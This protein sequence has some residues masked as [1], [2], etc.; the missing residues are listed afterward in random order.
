MGRRIAVTGA[1]GFIGG[2]LVRWLSR[3]GWWIRILTRHPSASAAAVDEGGRVEAVVGSLDDRDSLRR[4]VGGV[5][6]V[7]HAAGLVK[8]RSRSDFFRVNADGVRRLVE[9]TAEQRPRPPRFILI[10]SL[11]AR[12]PRLSAYAASKHAGEAALASAGT[13][14][15]WTILR[16][17]AVYGPGDRQTL[18]FFRCVSAGVGPLLGAEAARFSLLHVDDLAAAVGAVL[19]DVS[20]RGCTCEPDDGQPGGYSWRTVA[21]VAGNALGVRPRVIAVPKSVLYAVGALNAVLGLVTA[22]AAVLTPG[23]VRELRYPDWVCDAA[24]IGARTAWRPVWPLR[25]GFVD[26]VGWYRRYGWL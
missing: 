7:V 13:A 4:L 21:A 2:R 11:A 19:E 25:E 20:V 16:P 17:P 6:A 5:D 23:K 14:L 26:T 12:E 9:V 10:S 1:T 8:A 18:A 22:R 3:Q 15:H 24:T